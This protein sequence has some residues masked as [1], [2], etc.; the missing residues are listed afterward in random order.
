MLV[1]F[2]LVNCRR[3]HKPFM[4]E[5][6]ASSESELVLFVGLLTSFLIMITSYGGG[7]REVERHKLKI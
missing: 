4:S 2:H 5:K 6:S 7:V 3:E 1:E